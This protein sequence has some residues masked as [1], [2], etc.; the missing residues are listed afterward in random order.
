MLCILYIRR[1][2]PRP[3]TTIIINCFILFYCLA[4]FLLL[5]LNLNFTIFFLVLLFL[6]FLLFNPLQL[7][8]LLKLR[9]TLSICFTPF[10]SNTLNLRLLFPLLLNPKLLNLLNLSLMKFLHTS[11]SWFNS[12]IDFFII[13]SL[14]S[15]FA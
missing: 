13:N 5:I 1:I 15:S 3:N 14:F 11:Y 12:I 4:P 9:K 8:I 7:L 2:I 10:L 6:F